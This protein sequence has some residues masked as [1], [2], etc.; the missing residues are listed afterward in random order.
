MQ[1]MV[2]DGEA[3]ALVAERVWQEVSRGLMEPAPLR[4]LEV[5]EQCNALAATLPGITLSDELRNALQWCTENSA[6]LSSRVG[7][8]ALTMG[9]ALFKPLAKRL[10]IPKDCA[11]I[12][13]L[14]LA[15][16][17]AILDV[18]S[19]DAAQ[20]LTTI[21]RIDGLRRPE[22]VAQILDAVRAVHRTDIKPACDRL[23][24]AI[25]VAS[26]VDAGAIARPLQQQGSQAIAQAVALARQ[27]AISE[28]LD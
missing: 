11:D 3:D 9:D 2:A 7:A 15:Q 19:A 17:Q 4:M 5:L 8:I 27:Q 6:T 25:A 1:Q 13:T 16:Q 20:L 22:R 21:E 12:A 14:A 26:A 18:P 28:L 10:R 23:G 24:D